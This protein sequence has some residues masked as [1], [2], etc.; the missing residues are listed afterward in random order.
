MKKKTTT[1]KKKKKKK[2]EKS[3]P[4]TDLELC[5]IRDIAHKCNLVQDFLETETEVQLPI[6]LIQ[7]PVIFFL[8][9]SLKNNLSRFRYDP[10][11]AL[12]S[13][14]V[15]YLQGAPKKSTYLHS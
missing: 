8:F 4:T 5:L 1:K 2:H 10:Q 9:I 13:A 7:V 6:R 15:Q 3:K 12:G 14:N 11:I